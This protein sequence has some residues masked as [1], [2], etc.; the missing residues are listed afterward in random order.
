MKESLQKFITT[1]NA[2]KAQKDDYDSFTILEIMGLDQTV[3]NVERNAVD[4]E[5]LQ[6]ALD[7]AYLDYILEL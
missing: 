3:E 7:T 5:N 4:V 6:N 2:V 1:K